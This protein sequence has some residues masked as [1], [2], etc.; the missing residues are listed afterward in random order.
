[1]KTT[2]VTPSSSVNA[3]VKTPVAA[4]WTITAQYI[5]GNRTSGSGRDMIGL[6]VYNNG[7]NRMYVSGLGDNL[8]GVWAYSSP[9]S[10]NSGPANK[11][12]L[13]DS[14]VV[15]SRIEY[16]SS[17]TQLTFYYSIDGFTWEQVF[18]TT[19]PYVGVPTAYGI[20]VGS[21]GNAAGSILSLSY[22]AETSP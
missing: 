4:S 12:I 3:L 7:T 2:Q 16:I 9:T 22:F 15:W 11:T 17:S 1:L 14:N 6:V 10:W 20:A 8:F 13:R 18:T 21:Q 5:Q 19:S